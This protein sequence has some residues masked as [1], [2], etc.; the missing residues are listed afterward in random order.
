MFTSRPDVYLGVPRL[1][2]V[3]D[4]HS[5]AAPDSAEPAVDVRSVTRSFGTADRA[6]T[7]VRDLSLRVGEGEILAVV[8]PSG[9]GKT[10]L[11]QMLAGFLPPSSGTILIHGNPVNGVSRSCTLMPQADSLFPWL[12][13]RKNVRFANPAATD[14]LAERYLSAVDLEAFADRWPRELSAGMRKRAEVARAYASA[15]DILLL[16]EPF[17]ALDVLT[18][19]TM[20]LVLHSVWMSDQRTIIFVTHDV[21]EA[22]FIAHR[23]AVFSPRPANIATV[24]ESSFDFPRDPSIKFAADFISRRSR[25]IAAL[26]GP[27]GRF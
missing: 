4:P 20:Q 12:T 8:G 17:G 7:A 13:V 16:D 25:I 27:S 21:E 2:A 6:I 18:K 15:A 10:T 9:C 5:S 14:G 26:R 22:L 24:V 1:T 23:V 11:L 19:E 3:V